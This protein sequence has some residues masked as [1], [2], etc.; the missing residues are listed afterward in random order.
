MIERIKILKSNS[1]YRIGDLVCRQG[2]RW[3]SDIETILLSPRYENSILRKYLNSFEFPSCDP[4]GDDSITEPRGISDINLLGEICSK[5]KTNTNDNTL[6]IHIRCGD[7]VQ[8]P[9]S[10]YQQFWLFNRQS[11]K[12][13][14]KEKLNK[15][16]LNKVEFVCSMHFGDYR[17]KSLYL[18]SEASVSEN[19]SLLKTM[20]SDISSIVACDVFEGKNDSVENIDYHFASLVSARHVIL[21]GGGFSNIVRALRSL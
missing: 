2:Y 17:E 11:L 19:I 4:F 5:V 8:L 18:Y 10:N 3:R 12:S 6:Y 16:K 13:L 9:K 20:F 21:D 7:I 1:S 14:I 15:E